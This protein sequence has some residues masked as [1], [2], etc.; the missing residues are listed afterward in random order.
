LCVG[1]LVRTHTFKKEEMPTK[2]EMKV[3]H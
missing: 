3:I 2:V 1:L